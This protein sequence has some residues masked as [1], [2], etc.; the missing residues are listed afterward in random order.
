MIVSWSN[1]LTLG[2]GL[3]TRRAIKRTIFILAM[4]FLVSVMVTQV[5][6]GENP[7]LIFCKICV[8]SV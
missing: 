6:L 4:C 8:P 1:S 3:M 7:E 2:W 5:T